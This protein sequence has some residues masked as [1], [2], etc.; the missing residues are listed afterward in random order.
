MHIE[1]HG[2]SVQCGDAA[3][4]GVLRPVGLNIDKYCDKC[5]AADLWSFPSSGTVGRNI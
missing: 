1:D 3:Q 5:S 2:F 4:K